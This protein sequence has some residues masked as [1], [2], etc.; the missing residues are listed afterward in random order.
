MA[1]TSYTAATTYV[2]GYDW[3]IDYGSSTTTTIRLGTL[4]GIS[5]CTTSDNFGNGYIDVLVR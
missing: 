4:E 1:T 5:G 2:G 3:V